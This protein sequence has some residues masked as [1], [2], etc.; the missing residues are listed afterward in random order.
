MKRIAWLAIGLL[1]AILIPLL[2][3][4]GDIFQRL[5]SFPFAL[6]MGMFGMIILCWGLNTANS[7]T[8]PHPAAAVGR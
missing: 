3:G 5:R 1:A 7:P 2:L 4:G 6:L 8:A